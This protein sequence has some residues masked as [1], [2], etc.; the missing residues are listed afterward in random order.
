MG[1]V[2]SIKLAKNQKDILFDIIL[3]HKY[4]HLINDS[5]HFYM[6]GAV[7]VDASLDGLYLNIGSVTSIIN[8]GIVFETKDLNEKYSKKSFELLPSHKKYQEKEYLTTGGKTFFLTADTLGSIKKNSPIIFKGLKVGTVIDYALNKVQDKV[9]IKVYI[10]PKYTE[11]INKSTTFYN[12]S[13]IQATLGVDGVKIDTQSIES[14][15]TGGI[16]FKTP[17]YAKDVSDLHEF[18]LFKNQDA[19]DG[20]Y[21]QVTLSMN[22]GYD[23]KKGSKVIYKSITV[24][25]VKSIDLLN[26][27]VQ[28]VV[29][30]NK[31]YSRILSDDSLFW[32]ENFDFK[33]TR[34]DNA[35]ALIGGAFITVLVGKS[36]I[37]SDHFK[38]LENAPAESMNKDGLRVIVAGPRLSSLKKDTPVFY[39]QIQI[40]NVEQYWLSGDSKNVELI[41]FIDKCYRYLVRKN[42]KFYNTSAFGVDISLF[43]VTISTETLSTMING[44]IA[45]VTPTEAKEE[46]TDM[47]SFIL[48]PEPDEDWLEWEPELLHD[49]TCDKPILR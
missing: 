30:I 45:L 44:G 3:A 2:H 14:I 6:Q 49:T 35:S 38:L 31:K 18:K 19:V 11:H 42:S 12:I 40:G 32:A 17:L 37:M 4:K 43:G 13:G 25:H 39:R 1:S 47:E 28:A 41:L 48:H 23:L 5:S 27:K 46:V 36:E 7:E 16:A 22:R 26:D 15:I 29:L 9:F 20:K 10:N 24:G 33:L 34:I 21:K 8:G